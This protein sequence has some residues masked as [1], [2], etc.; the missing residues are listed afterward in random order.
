MN[1]QQWA[2]ILGSAGLIALLFFGFNTK[3]PKQTLIEKSRAGGVEIQELQNALRAALAVLPEE[4]RKYFQGL[5]NIVESTQEDSVR[6]DALMSLSAA[7]YRQNAYVIAG[8]CAER[9]AQIGN[10][11]EQWALAGTT[12]AAGLTAGTESADHEMAA[13][14]A[15]RCL[16]NAISLN[17]RNPDNRINLAIS[18]VEAPP[19]DNPM[20]GIQ[21]LLELNR[22]NPENVSV[23]FHLARFGM[24]TGQYAKAEERLERAL[25]LDPE[26]RRLHCLMAELQQQAGQPDAATIYQQK[27]DQKNELN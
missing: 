14:G 10:T 25:S 21:L 5:E 26:E 20:K 24:R 8:Y 1:T 18:Y 23:L 4:S 2:L 19:A 9:I 15:I 6:I 13:A 12:Y 22:N 7:W 11:E 17:P 3:P 16:E 27:C